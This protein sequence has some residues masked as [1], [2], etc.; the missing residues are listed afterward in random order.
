MNKQQ[1]KAYIQIGTKQVTASLEV[2]FFEEDGMRIAYCPS[3]NLSAYGR[4][5]E[6]AKREFALL[7]KEYIEDCI[8]KQTLALDLSRHGWR[9]QSKEYIAPQ[10]TDM[11]MNNDTLRDIVNNRSYKKAVVPTT[12]N[13]VS[14]PRVQAWYVNTKTFKY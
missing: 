7:F 2:Y 11:L 10:T 13:R 14:T 1:L 8:V 4:N 3:L 12:Y 5:I 6:E 9:L